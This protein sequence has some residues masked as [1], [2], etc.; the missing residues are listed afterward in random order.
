MMTIQETVNRFVDEILEEHLQRLRVESPECQ[1]I[2][3][4]LLKLSDKVHV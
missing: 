2:D 4:R 3:R 1:D